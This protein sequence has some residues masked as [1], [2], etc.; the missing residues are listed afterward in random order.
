MGSILEEQYAEFAWRMEWLQEAEQKLT[1]ARANR[2]YLDGLRPP[3]NFHVTYHTEQS[4]AAQQAGTAEQDSSVGWMHRPIW[5]CCWYATAMLIDNQLDV[6]HNW[7]KT[8]G[9]RC[10][11]ICAA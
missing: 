5:N 9:K 10:L 6:G 8:S 7:R 4:N 11:L 3:D 1:V 2:L